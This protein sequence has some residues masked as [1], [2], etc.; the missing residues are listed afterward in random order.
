M[1]KRS[2]DMRVTAIHM[3]MLGK[4]LM[5]FWQPN[6]SNSKRSSVRQI[7]QSSEPIRVKFQILMLVIETKQVTR[8]K[9]HLLIEKGNMNHVLQRTRITVNRSEC[10]VY[11]YVMQNFLRN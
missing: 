4:T 10:M 7:L 5:L 2:V 6:I 1:K 3:K 9:Q 11:R 8:K